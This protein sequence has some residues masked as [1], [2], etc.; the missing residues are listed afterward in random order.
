MGTR[1]TTTVATFELPDGFRMDES[2]ENGFCLIRDKTLISVFPLDD[3]GADLL[4]HQMKNLKATMANQT[5]LPLRAFRYGNNF[6]H[7]QEIV[8]AMMNSGRGGKSAWKEI[9]FLLHSGHDKYMIHVTDEK[10]Y[11]VSDY[12]DFLA[13]ISRWTQ[14]EDAT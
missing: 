14:D 1:L 12:A 6:G 5:I 11:E 10:L 4:Y 9:K 3:F 8:L 13:S 7:Y 2:D